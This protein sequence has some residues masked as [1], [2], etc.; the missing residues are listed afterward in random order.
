M[1]QAA[2]NPMIE[3]FSILPSICVVAR[4]NSCEQ[5]IR[6]QWRLSHASN[7]CLFLVGEEKALYCS[8]MQQLTS[9]VL[10]LNVQKEN[11]FILRLG[12]SNKEMRRQLKVRELGKDVR[13]SRRHLWSV[14]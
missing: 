12:A 9:I 4:E 1:I 10:R 8:D 5:D 3:S 7:S 6:F 13:Q 11:E 2:N 14:F